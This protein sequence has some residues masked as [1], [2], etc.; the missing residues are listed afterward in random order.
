MAIDTEKIKAF[1]G[2]KKQQEEFKARFEQLKGQRKE[3][4]KQLK[5]ATG[6]ED[7]DA[8]NTLLEDLERQLNDLE[9]A[10]DKDTT[11]LIKKYPELE[12]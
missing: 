3:Y 2:L 9:K 6:T 10:I 5:E 8:A 11:A 1:E 7:I 12:K 4:L